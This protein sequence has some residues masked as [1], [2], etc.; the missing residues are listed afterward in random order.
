MGGERMGSRPD[1]QLASVSIGVSI[2]E[3]ISE[4]ISGSS[5]RRAGSARRAS[6]A[7]FVAA[8]PR[9]PASFPPT[10]VATTG[11]P[12][13]ARTAWRRRA[14]HT[15][16]STESASLPCARH[17][18]SPD[19]RGPQS[20]LAA[21]AAAKSS[22]PANSISMTAST[23]ACELTARRAKRRP[24][25]ASRHSV[26][27]IQRQSAEGHFGRVSDTKEN[28]SRNCTNRDLTP[29]FYPQATLALSLGCPKIAERKRLPASLPTVCAAERR[30]GRYP[31]EWSFGHFSQLLW[32]DRVH[33]AG[34]ALR[35]HDSVRRCA[36]LGRAGT[37]WIQYLP[38]QQRSKFNCLTIVFP[39]CL[40][41]RHE[42]AATKIAFFY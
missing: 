5:G 19:I 9:T 12:L 27:R 3:S 35:R 38:N 29:K 23:T 15:I 7:V 8:R 2:G 1:A 13:S 21:H 16:A 11:L 37:N 42:E 40:G 25:S 17:G 24:L 4:N 32:T 30:Q 31:E 22:R 26:R 10:P 18:G 14:V 20:L 6:I 33:A 28:S 39:C 41:Y 34:S 36:R